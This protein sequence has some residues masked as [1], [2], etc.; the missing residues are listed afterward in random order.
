[1]S[2]CLT[3]SNKVADDSW[4]TNIPLIDGFGTEGIGSMIQFHLLLLFYTDFI[5]VD[6]VY[7]GSINFGHHS[8][9]GYAENEYHNLIDNFFNF[10]N[11]KNDWDEVYN[12]SNMDDKLFS[13]IE[14]KHKTTEKIL[15]NLHNCHIQIQNICNIN[16]N[17]IFTENRIDKIRNN[18]I[19]NGK[20]YFEDCLNISLHIR[21]ENPNDVPSEVISPFRECYNFNRDFYRYKNLINFLKE[22]TKNQKSI[23]HIHSQGF[24]TNFTEFLEFKTEEFDIQLHIDDD[25]ISDLYHM[26]NS[27][28]FI[29]ANSAFSWIASLLNKNKKIVRDNHH[30]FTIN[31]LKANYDYTEIS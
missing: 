20:K 30:T 21:T 22:N 10:P 15:I 2:I 31:S 12:V 7:P 6:F 25:P 3:L 8:Y 16:R 11:V 26:S 19:F 27:D 1:M 28:L 23:L 5:G 13:F 14:T 17:N 24:T 18:L 4:K 29:M 9:S